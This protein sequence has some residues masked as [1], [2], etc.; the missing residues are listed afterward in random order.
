MPGPNVSVK[1]LRSARAPFR[2]ALTQTLNN[3]VAE[4][5]A[6]SPELRKVRIL[7]DQLKEKARKLDEKDDLVTQALLNSYPDGGAELDQLLAENGV[8]QNEYRDKVSEALTDANML[9]TSTNATETCQ[10]GRSTSDI[11][12]E[13][14]AA[15]AFKVPQYNLPKFNGKDLTEYPAWIDQF[16]AL[17][18]K[19]PQ[20]SSVQ[21]F[22]ILK[23]RLTDDAKQVIAALMTTAENYP[24]ALNILNE[25]YGDNNLLIGLFV[26]NLHS[27]KTVKDARS[28]DLAKLVY[29]FDRGY[30]E[31][32]NLFNKLSKEGTEEIDFTSFF[33]TPHLLSKLPES[34][35]LRWYDKNTSPKD[36]YNFQAL[37][38]YLKNE[39]KGRQTCNV[40]S[41]SG[42]SSRPEKN[43]HDGSSNGR[44]FDRSMTGAFF[45]TTPTKQQCPACKKL[46]H[47]LHACDDFLKMTREEKFDLVQKNGRCLNCLSPD[48]WQKDCR[49]R[50]KCRECG[51]QQHHT[52]L[53]SKKNQPQRS[54]DTP[55]MVASLPVTRDSNS[56]LQV[57]EV[58]VG[59]PGD[60]HTQKTFALLDSA[61]ARS[62]IHSDLAHKLGLEPMEGRQSLSIG[63]FGG[64]I[65][66]KTSSNVAC[67]IT[68]IQDPQIAIEVHPWTI[69][70]LMAPLQQPV[71]LPR[72]LSLLGRFTAYDGAPKDIGLV[73]GADCFY[74]VITNEVI[75]GRP[76]AVRTIFGWTLAGEVPRDRGQRLPIL[77]L[78]SRQIDD[79]FELDAIGI[80]EAPNAVIDSYSAPKLKNNRYEVRLPF[81]SERRPALNRE[82]ARSRLLSCERRLTAEQR[83]Q[84]DAQMQADIDCGM[85]ERSTNSDMGYYMPHRA[86]F[87]KGKMRIVFDASSSSARTLSLNETLDPGPNL[88]PLLC[89]VLQRFRL[90]KVPLV[91]DI[92]AAFHQ[93]KI[94]PDDRCWVQFLW[95]G[96]SWMFTVVPF[97]I[98]SGPFLLL[99]ALQELYSTLDVNLG[100]ILQKSTYMDDIVT[101]INSQQE[102][103]S[104]FS[105]AKQA[106]ASVGME[107][108]QPESEK[109]LGLL[110]DK[111]Q[112]TLAVPMASLKT[113]TNFSRRELLSSLASVF[114][115]SGIV[116]PYLILGRMLLQEAWRRGKDQPTKSIWDTPLDPDLQSQWREWILQQYH[117]PV[118]RWVHFSDSEEVVWHI[119]CDASTKAYAAVI[120]FVLPEKGISSLYFAK[121][122]VSPLRS[123]MTVPRA[124]LLALTVGVRLASHGSKHWMR[125]TRIVFW[126][127][128]QTVLSWLRSGPPAKQVFIINRLK[129]IRSL[130]QD[131]PPHEFRYVPTEANPADW[132]SRGC[133][134]S[135]L[136]DDFWLKGPPFLRQS[137]S[138]W[139]MGLAVDTVVNLTTVDPA[140]QEAVE[141]CPIDALRFSSMGK[142]VRVT[143]W[144]RRYMK[145]L[146]QKQPDKRTSGPLTITELD[147]AL[148]FWLRRE[149]Q[150][151][152]PSEYRRLSNGQT[153]LS[154]SAVRRLNPRWNAEL[155][156]ITTQPRTLE[157]GRILLP[158][159]SRITELLILQTHS[160][161]LHSGPRCTL[162]E[163][164]RTYWIVHGLSSVKRYLSSCRACRRF[165]CQLYNPEEGA[166]PSFR[167]TPAP[168][169]STVGVDHFGPILS[170]SG[171]K[172]WV[173]LI[174]CAVTRAIHLELCTNLTAAETHHSLRNFFALRV[175]AGT[176]VKVFSDNAP[177]FVKASKLLL[178]NHQMDWKFIPER[179]PHFGGF[180]ERLVRTVKIAMT[181]SF[182]GQAF[183]K[184][185]LA[186]TLYE[187][188]SIINT[189]P[190]TTPSAE[191][192]D[193]DAL[194]PSHF[195]YGA[196]PS[197]Q[198]QRNFIPPPDI[199]NYNRQRTAV[200][201]EF[202]RRWKVE[203]LSTLRTWRTGIKK[204]KNYTSIKEGDVVL[205][206]E[207]SSRG[208]WPMAKVES[209]LPSRDGTI[210]AANILLNGRKTRRA[211][212]HLALLEAAATQ[213][214]FNIQAPAYVP[215]TA[216]VSASSDDNCD[217]HE[218]APYE[219]EQ[220]TR[221]RS[222]RVAKP[223]ARYQSL[224]N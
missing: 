216:Y 215:A 148:K 174:T 115:P 2:T 213:A 66:E 103:K 159:R 156:L 97:G 113:P 14:A 71:R 74:K 120:Y 39:L 23:D 54:N 149:Q 34:I 198:L 138:E 82:I 38:S 86:V 214:P 185:Q 132:P 184:K 70:T 142:L 50:Y 133:P 141:R 177:T 203:Y 17:I 6:E 143:A 155:A 55:A 95:Q 48:H 157:E 125:P 90:R 173:L 80:L 223:V 43:T 131:L 52:T 201:Q 85:I 166:L 182:R 94:H 37:V 77:S 163:T 154:T 33:L 12:S 136:H 209:L 178:P 79:L 15:N 31:I 69:D 164:R 123:K 36:R 200:A 195:L 63:T 99:R 127:D 76:T 5:N 179:S 46:K 162:A 197:G 19:H 186:L 67:I 130:A 24:R 161:R 112:D 187:I 192:Y 18:H 44:R 158:S 60:E 134:A 205:V 16:D 207:P 84:Y 89:D 87:S 190:L 117:L 218:S 220:Q 9:L 28:T 25:N 101:S 20:L 92:T 58:E 167:V 137:P 106:L 30:G 139:P 56:V 145:N 65:T 57:V 59:R 180:W 100:D 208:R 4:I 68:S 219:V 122:R 42:A 169:F 102:S 75:P 206:E 181:S 202:W 61:A 62:W 108:R 193:E 81:K 1:A 222:G 110:F 27:Y 29:G 116:A 151:A 118:P 51:S 212:K 196:P 176:T 64:G 40:L 140:T 96:E 183:T 165:T 21:K 168:V 11:M 144:V 172:N 72:R 221:T 111:E 83:K 35:Q 47:P 53:C 119:F 88:L 45:Q 152:F 121:A 114:D 217:N 49:S 224:R 109:V 146:L 199:E 7:V 107:L 204:D 135:R 13:I 32:Q 26:A 93:L 3:L 211:L 210:R 124:E 153:P 126:S 91:C 147:E 104:I 105:G 188:A 171:A 129:E 189:R 22:G 160:D 194:T 128:S 78:F 10:D 73:I 41:H 98:S 8:V 191:P 175:P 170:K 150:L